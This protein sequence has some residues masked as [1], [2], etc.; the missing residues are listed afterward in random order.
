[1]EFLVLKDTT[2]CNFYPIDSKFGTQVGLVKIKVKFEDGLCGSHKGHH[3][4][5]KFE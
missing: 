3:K 4:K 1:M 2:G 5:T